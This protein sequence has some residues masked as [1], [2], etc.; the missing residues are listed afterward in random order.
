MYVYYVLKNYDY[1]TTVVIIIIFINN[2]CMILCRYLY[3]IL[4]VNN[5]DVLREVE[6]RGVVEV[7]SILKIK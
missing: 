3:Y 7:M 5:N 4:Y 1:N 2:I 6:V